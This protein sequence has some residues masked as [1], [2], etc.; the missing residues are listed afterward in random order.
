MCRL[1]TRL[2]AIDNA[3]ARREVHC[4]WGESS[5]R[6]CIHSCRGRGACVNGSC[7][8]DTGFSGVDCSMSADAPHCPNGAPQPRGIFIGEEGLHAT[9]GS[10]TMSP[11]RFGYAH[12]CKGHPITTLEPSLNGIYAP[13]DIFL[14]RLLSDHTFRSL[15]RSCAQAEWHPMYARR[16]YH[17]TDL[18]SK[19]S[20]RAVL[21]QRRQS[22]GAP[23]LPWIHE[24]HSDVGSCGEPLDHFT[25]GDILLTYWGHVA[26]KP[27]NV[28]LVVVPGGTRHSLVLNRTEHRWTSMH[29]ELVTWARRV[30]SPAHLHAPRRPVLYFQGSTREAGA[31]ADVVSRCFFP[32][33]RS[34]GC[35]QGVYSLGIRQAVRRTIGSDARVVFNVGKTGGYLTTLSQTEFCLTAPGFGFGVRII[36]YVATG[37]L[38]V[39]VRVEPQVLLPLEPD[40]DYSAFAVSIPFAAIGALPEILANM[41]S[42]E[43]RRKREA[44]RDVHKQFI[45]DE[46][47]GQAYEAVLG[48][49]QRRLSRRHMKP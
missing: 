26:C 34:K 43:I 25:E 6:C 46:G 33:N 42:T 27:P 5:S 49:L 21:R 3:C 14:L 28:F 10:S 1:R 32:H 44:L 45:W 19:W 20:I 4:T 7:Q 2:A 24:D 31:S 13:I 39:I 36:D 12:E 9:G 38:P 29:P 41:S 22:R 17:N 37:C 11:A 35:G 16:I 18:V 40:L 48:A 8:C 15:S 30:Y 23:M 47:Y